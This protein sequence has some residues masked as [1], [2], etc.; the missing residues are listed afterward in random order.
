MLGWR[1]RALA[2]SLR[3]TARVLGHLFL[4]ALLIPAILLLGAL[5]VGCTAA[6]LAPF[7]ALPILHT[8]LAWPSMLADGLT[9]LG[10]SDPRLVPVAIGGLAWLGISS[11]TTLLVIGF[12]WP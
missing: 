7:V 10:V 12:R 5:V 8:T 3:L 9:A 1:R 2:V 11:A 4:L 6:L